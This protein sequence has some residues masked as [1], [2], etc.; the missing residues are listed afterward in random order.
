MVWITAFHCSKLIRCIVASRV[1]PALLT[2]TST[3]PSAASIAFT[4][5]CAGGEIG[6]VELEDR[7]AGLVGELLRRLVVAGVIG[8]DLVAGVLQRHRDRPA[9]AA[10]P[11]GDHR[12]PEPCVS[13]PLSSGQPTWAPLSFSRRSTHIAM[14]MPP[15]M[16][17]V[18]RP[19]L[20]SR[21]CISYSRV[22][23]TRAPG[24]ADRMA[25]RDGAAVD[26]D[27]RGIP[28]EVLVDR[29]G[30]GGEG[31]VGLDQVEVVGRPAG[32]LQRHAAGR[33]R[34][35]AHDRRI[36]AGGRPGDDARQRLQAALLRPRLA[37]ISTTAAAPSLMPEALP[38]VTVPFLSKAGRSF[39]QRPRRWC[40]AWDT[41]RCRRPSR[42]CGSRS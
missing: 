5:V 27:L 42:P 3:G 26:V 7:D 2:S 13:L 9:D 16:H 20:A 10:R 17:R 8:G 32:L 38:A 15:P 36:D 29:A 21:R 30:L 22:T 35:G 12:H 25:E 6:D 1:M 14:P 34:P 11:A 41:R 23:S 33:D 39:G 24:R 19:F 28:A 4:P 37:V 40:R 18:A 31:L